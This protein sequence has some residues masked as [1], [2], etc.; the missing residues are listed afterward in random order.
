MYTT[1]GC[2]YLAYVNVRFGMEQDSA[3]TRANFDEWLQ[4]QNNNAVKY[5]A[6]GKLTLPD[7]LI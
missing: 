6:N 1:P 3:N 4:Y 2:R 7:T 5:E